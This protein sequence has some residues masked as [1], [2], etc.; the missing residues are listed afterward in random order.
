MAIASA[1]VGKPISRPNAQVPFVDPETG[2]LT[3]HGLQLLSSWREAIV[4]ANRV[5]P[6]SASGTDVVTLTPNEAAPLI[7][8]YVD[9]EVFI[10]AAAETST[11]DVTATVVPRTGALDTLKVYVDSGATQATAG[12][13]VQNSVYLW[14]YADHLDGGAGGFVLK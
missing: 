9:Y 6:C 1:A 13:I 7:E 11:G 8:K 12:D 5:I 14:I 4:G 10:A 2:I 3:A